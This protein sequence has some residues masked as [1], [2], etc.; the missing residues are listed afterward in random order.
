MTLDDLHLDHLTLRNVLALAPSA[1]P[2]GQPVELE[3]LVT[4]LRAGLEAL[5]ALEEAQAARFNRDQRE[6]L[7]DQIDNIP[8]EPKP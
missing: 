4:A 3:A 6:W 8:T 2:R 1:P 5:A 7:A